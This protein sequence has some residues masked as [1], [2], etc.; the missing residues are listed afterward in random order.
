M[1]NKTKGNP[2][3]EERALELSKFAAS[4]N[5][6]IT[7]YD[8]LSM[9]LTH[10]S[11]AFEATK[12]SDKFIKHNERI[13]FL[14]DSVLSTIVSTYMFEHFR[15]LDEGKLTKFRAH[16]VCEGSLSK[17]AKE[18]HLG[19]YLLLGHGEELSGSRERPSILADAF[20]AVLGAIYLD[21]GLELATK[22]L[23][24]LMQ[25]EIDFVCT[26]GIYDD[27]KSYL[28]EYLQ[29]N[30]EVHIIYKITGSTGL[31]HEKT[32]QANVSLDGKILGSG[33]GKS[34]KEAE[35]QAAKSALQ[36]FGLS[37]RL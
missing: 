6:P 14:G 19:D 36:K 26:H 11:Y 18:I 16:L 13:E 24:G 20:E 4:I 33:E 3:S 30:G 8:L 5:V 23:L 25:E 32:F 2:I 35:Q 22:Y 29:Q 31:A 15:G 28:Q 9:A 1:L 17:F 27:Y 12:A 7:R 34:K 37:I 21:C 10:S